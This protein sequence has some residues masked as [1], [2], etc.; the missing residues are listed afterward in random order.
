MKS[1][2]DFVQGWKLPAIIIAGSLELLAFPAE[3]YVG[4]GAG[5]TL[6]G[7]LWAVL[8]A[9]LLALSGLLIWPIRVLRRRLRQRKAGGEP[10]LHSRTQEP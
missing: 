5:V 2:R 1:H 9:V 4:P 3:A 6:L 8:L 7:A 10:E